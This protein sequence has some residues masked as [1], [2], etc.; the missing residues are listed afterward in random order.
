MKKIFCSLE[1]EHKYVIFLSE[2]TIDMLKRNCCCVPIDYFKKKDLNNFYKLYQTERLLTIL[3]TDNINFKEK[4]IYFD[5]IDTHIPKY[6]NLYM[7]VNENFYISYSEY[8]KSITQFNFNLYSSVFTK[9]G[10][11]KITCE[12]SK[13]IM[14]KRNISN[15]LNAGIGKVSVQ[16]E[17]KNDKNIVEIIGESFNLD[18]SDY[19][20]I[21]QF[22][23]LSKKERK[24]K[25]L[26]HLPT[27]IKGSS[28]MFRNSLDM[29]KINKAI[30]DNLSVIDYEFD[31]RVNE[32]LNIYVGLGESYTPLNIS[33]N[34]GFELEKK[35]NQY[36]KI[37]YEFYDFKTLEQEYQ[38]IK[39]C[40]HT[41]EYYLSTANGVR[42]PWP[43]NCEKIKSEHHI[44]NF[45]KA[46]AISTLAIQKDR[47]NIV[48]EIRNDFDIW[49]GGISYSV[50]V[51]KLNANANDIDIKIGA[52]IRYLHFSNLK[53]RQKIK[54]KRALKKNGY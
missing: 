10:L 51:W 1:H 20:R 8:L 18:A 28:V 39:K 11:K 43:T 38:A 37:N 13:S 6:D 4:Q 21:I 3:N 50:H 19:A 46:L 26:E 23:K 32:I 41:K 29:N 33:N 15:Q 48:V 12:I 30:D 54:L 9:F 16:V 5:D 14:K 22:R 40:S 7:K 47:E 42:G 44:K 45:S 31:I 17:Q 35:E 25:M 24:D 2:F 52:G 49:N 36:I 34:F 27:N 53:F